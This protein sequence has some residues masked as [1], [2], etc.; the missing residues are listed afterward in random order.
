MPGIKEEWNLLDNTLDQWSSIAAQNQAD[1][2]QNCQALERLRYTFVNAYQQVNEVSN[3]FHSMQNAVNRIHNMSEN[4]GIP[5]GSPRA[6]ATQA[7][8]AK[9][10][11]DEGTSEYER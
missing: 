3:T 2:L 4:L 7:L 9:C 6:L 11:A 5:A 10:R 8:F 1:S